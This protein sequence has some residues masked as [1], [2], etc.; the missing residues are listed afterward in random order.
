MMSEGEG[1][2]SSEEGAIVA[3]LHDS[4]YLEDLHE[5][6]VVVHSG[7]KLGLF[8]LAGLVVCLFAWGLLGGLP[9]EI[10]GRGVFIP[11]QDQSTKNAADNVDGVIL[12]RFSATHAGIIMVGDDAYIAIDGISPYAHG[13]IKAKV[14]APP[15]ASSSSDTI[16][17]IVRPMR[18]EQMFSGYDWTLGKGP[19]TI[20]A[21]GTQCEVTVIVDR[22]S[23]LSYFRLQ[24]ENQQGAKA[25]DDI[26]H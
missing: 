23:P 19:E 13:M 22:V 25:S 9:L 21:E 8:V 16:Q 4:M 17:V 10:T 26:T 5:G 14:S 1:N 6:L 12:A 18:N 15:S 2:D 24:W 11:Q 3:Q 7:S 20:I